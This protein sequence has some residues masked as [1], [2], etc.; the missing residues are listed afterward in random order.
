MVSE[1]WLSDD[2]PDEALCF[3]SILGFSIIRNDGVNKR[4]GVVAVFIN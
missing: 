1:A 4:G 3:P 2:I